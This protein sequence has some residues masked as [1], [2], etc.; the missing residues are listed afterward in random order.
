[1]CDVRYC[2]HG[3]LGG[4][5]CVEVVFS[6]STMVTFCA[7]EGTKST[8]CG[9]RPCALNRHKSLRAYTHCNTHCNTLLMYGTGA[10][11]SVL[12]CVAV[13]CSE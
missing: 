6:I 12:Q 7:H 5:I 2:S 11:C 3:V 4:R 9:L 13:C 10:Y 8:V 1:M